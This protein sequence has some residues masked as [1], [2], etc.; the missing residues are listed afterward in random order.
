VPHEIPAVHPAHHLR[1]VH[2]FHIH[3]S[4]ETEQDRRNAQS[5]GDPGDQGDVAQPAL[6]ALDL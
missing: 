5:G 6:A 4:P 1:A 2:P 3:G